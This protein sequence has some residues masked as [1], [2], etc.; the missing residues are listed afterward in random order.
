MAKLKAQKSLKPKPLSTS[1]PH[2]F[3]QESQW[4]IFE[5]S[6]ITYQKCYISL[7]MSKHN[8]EGKSKQSIA[9]LGIVKATT[10]MKD[11]RKLKEIY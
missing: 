10:L 4:I 9:K 7:S 8:H 1:Q 2:N 5:F 6:I 11:I 3:L